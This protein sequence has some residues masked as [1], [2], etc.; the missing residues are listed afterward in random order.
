VQK[1][2]SG[3]NLQYTY[4]EKYCA[5]VVTNTVQFFEATNMNEVWKNL[6]VEGVTEVALSPGKNYSVAAF[7]PERKVNFNYLN[8]LFPVTIANLH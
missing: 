1:S 5:R 7:V 6:R 2:Q 8:P 3:W 4:D